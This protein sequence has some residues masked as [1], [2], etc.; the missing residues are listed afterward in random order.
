[1]M[2]REKLIGKLNGKLVLQQNNKD[3][4]NILLSVRSV[5]MYSALMDT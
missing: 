2:M 3:I 4:N 1:M 5:S